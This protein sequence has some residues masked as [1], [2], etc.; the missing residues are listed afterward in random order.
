MHTH[1][2][3]DD[4]FRHEYGKLVAA[5]TRRYGTQHL[6]HIED[7]VQEAM[8]AALS[9]WGKAGI[10]RRPAA[11]LQRVAHHRLVDLLRKRGGDI[12]GLSDIAD[13]ADPA[14][15]PAL[16]GDIASDQLRM[17]FV[18]CLPAVPRESQLVLALKLLCGFTT[19]EIAQRLFASEANVHKRLQRGRDKL[20]AHGHDWDQ[21]DQDTLR[22][23]TSS[24]RQVIYLLFNEGYSSRQAD[25]VIRR[26]LCEEAIY[27]GTVLA[28]HAVGD[29]PET[30]AL[31]ALMCFH[32]GRLEA[33]VD[34]QGGLLLLEEQDRSAW[35]AELIGRG[36]R[37]LYRSA[38]GDGFSR[39]HG[40]AAIAAA[41]CMASSFEHTRWSEVIELYEVL[42]RLEP[43]PLYTLNRAIAVAHLH[44]PQAGLDI[45]HG[46]DPPGWLAG[47]YLWDATLG[48]LERRAGHVERARKHLT[49]ALEAAPTLSEKALLERRLAACDP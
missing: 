30:W 27:L 13:A 39:Y 49:Q 5:L 20:R 24:V 48:E 8:V 37:Y 38:G 9:S 10:P 42:E 26:E 41:H 47:Y 43:S 6:G 15:D 21:L 2:R 19:E 33:R 1:E 18:C 7:A 12:H 31:L 22:E 3:I 14:I 35:D 46:I 25:T 44:G 4:C 29:Q 11:W 16:G 40:E 28:N 45:L 34:G 32:A 17:L 23:R 36:F